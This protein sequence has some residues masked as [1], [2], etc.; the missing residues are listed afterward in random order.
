MCP[1]GLPEGLYLRRPIE[2]KWVR[3]CDEVRQFYSH[4]L[5]G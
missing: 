2:G 4:L 1:T 5:E 3:A